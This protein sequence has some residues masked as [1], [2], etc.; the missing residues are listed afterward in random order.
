MDRFKST[1]LAGILGIMGNIFLLIIKGS[2]GF[3][4]NSQSMI[5]DSFNSASDIFASIMTFIGNKIASK[6]ND[7]DH[8][9]GHRK[10]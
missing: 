7:E 3:I 5:A 4:S 1:K 6:P 10:I 9:F 8:N 2:I